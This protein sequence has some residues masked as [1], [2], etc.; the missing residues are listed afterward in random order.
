MRTISTDVG[1]DPLSIACAANHGYRAGKRVVFKALKGGS[2]LTAGRTYYVIAA[3]LTD[4]AFRVSATKG[5]NALGFG[6]EITG[7][8][9][10]SKVMGGKGQNMGDTG[11]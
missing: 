3:G 6:S 1:T 11:G 7:G 4:R 10:R 8:V 2:G 9:V 5:G